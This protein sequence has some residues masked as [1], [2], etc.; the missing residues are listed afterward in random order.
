MYDPE[1]IPMPT[2]AEK[3]AAVTAILDAALPVPPRLWRTLGRLL[4]ELGPR[5]LFFGV[6]D[7][8]FLS[9]LAA[10]CCFAPMAAAARAAPSMLYALLFLLSP[11]L[12]GLLHLLTWWKEL[13]T[14]VWQWK[15]A[16]RIC[17][18]QLT[19]LRML[20]FGAVSL[21][22]SGL[23]GGALWLL[24]GRSVPLLRLLGVSFAALLL[25]AAALLSVQVRSRR[26]WAPLLVP[27]G[28]ALLSL[29]LQL[30]GDRLLPL[31]RALPAAALFPAA[32]AA[33]AV[34]CHELKRWLFEPREGVVSHAAG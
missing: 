30:L 19:A 8:V 15:A 12:Y 13:Q 22:A 34:Y 6:W 3:R 16:C 11:A 29:S 17:L 1:M 14:G 31:W 25:F 24:A 23:A 32:L 2:E 10:L 26:T 20:V 4:K 21:A 27:A 9:F 33:A 7:C 28:W 5:A 18:R